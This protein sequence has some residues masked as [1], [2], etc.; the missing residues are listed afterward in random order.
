MKKSIFMLFLCLALFALFAGPTW[1]GAENVIVSS[2]AEAVSGVPPNMVDTIVT[3]NFES[4][5][6]IDFH[7]IGAIG[8]TIAEI[9]TAST[10]TTYKKVS[11]A[12]SGNDFGTNLANAGISH[13]MDGQSLAA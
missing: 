8:S 1:G 11:T 5:T 12:V 13:P 10:A 2:R 6:M 4:M 9:A 7:P 3:S